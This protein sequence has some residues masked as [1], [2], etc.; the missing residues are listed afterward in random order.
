MITDVCKAVCLY[1]IL[2]QTA[3]LLKFFVGTY[4]FSSSYAWSIFQLPFLLVIS[5][6]GSCQFPA[7]KITASNMLWAYQWHNCETAEVGVG[8]RVTELQD[9]IS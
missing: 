6:P 8:W 2:G 1:C 5:K 9:K 3:I 7:Y 4:R